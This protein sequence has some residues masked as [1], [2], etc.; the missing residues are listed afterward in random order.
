MRGAHRPG[1]G[2]RES[3]GGDAVPPASARLAARQCGA[4][5]RRVASQL[6]HT[7]RGRTTCRARTIVGAGGLPATALIDIGL[8]LRLFALRLDWRRTRLGRGLYF[9]LGLL[10]RL[11]D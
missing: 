4:H 2:D 8:A 1:R 9:L 6:A 3:D 7:R 11:F 10:L 5:L